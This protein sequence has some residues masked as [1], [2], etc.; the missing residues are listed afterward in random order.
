MRNAITRQIELVATEAGTKALAGDVPIAHIER[1]RA[2]QNVLAA[3]PEKAM[4]PL[5]FAAIIGIACLLS[6]SLALVIHVPRTRAQ[7]DLTTTSVTMRLDNDLSWNGAWH[8]DPKQLTLRNFSSIE[9]PPEYGPRRASSLELSVTKGTVRVDD[10]FFG[11]GAMITIATNQAGVADIVVRGATFHGDIEVSGDVNA[12]TGPALEESLPPKQFDLEMPPGRFGFLYNGKDVLGQ[13]PPFMHSSPV[14][15]VDFPEVTITDLS[16]AD[17][18][19]KPGR[20][21]QIIFASQIVSGTLTM[22]DTGQQIALARG[23]AV[24]LA[25]IRG[26]ITALQVK[27]NQVQVKFEGTANAVTLGAGEFSRNLKPTIL[28]WLFHQ[29]RLGLFWGALTFLW[30]IAW[31]ARRL[32]FGLPTMGAATQRHTL[33]AGTFD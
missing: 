4:L 10:L 17:E 18:H 20:P 21:D 16:F 2:L 15:T 8:V 23:A 31:S 7:L 29:Q 24:H 13:Q 26:D 1:I 22:T 12:H 25:G 33:P 11:H 5:S 3:L 30:G 32:F 6:A 14:E 28:E 27:G 9:L 19:P